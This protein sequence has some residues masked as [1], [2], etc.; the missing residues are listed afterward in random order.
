MLNHSPWLNFER[1]EW[2]SLKTDLNCEVAIIGGGISGVATLYY[3]LISTQKRVVLFEKNRV[4]SGATGHN[5]GLAIA[6]IEKPASELVRM[7]GKEATQAIFNE[8]DEGWDALHTIHDEIGLKDNLLSFPHVVNG[9]NSLPQ[10]ISFLKEILIRNDYSQTD[11]RYLV[12]E[13]LK[14]DI[15]EEF[16]TIVEFVP[17]QTILIALKTIDASY[18]AATMRTSPFKGKRMNSAK[19]CYRVLD[20]LEER[21]PHRFS[22][23]EQTDITRIDLY[24]THSVLE[25]AHGSATSQEVILCTNAYKHFSI[26]DRINEKPYTKL[27]DSITPRIGYLVAF[28]NALLRDMPWL[29]SMS[30][31][32]LKMSLFGIFLMPHTQTTTLITHASWVDLNLI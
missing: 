7:L 13:S 27:Q 6:Y 15:P 24:E 8:L 20:Y 4:A 5:A 17:H 18:I 21:F 9:F 11:W 1:T 3:L 25:H 28:P 29:L 2:P 22:V 31:K 30:R 32:R 23:Y 16:S 14:E 26:W 12:S 19:F 10:F